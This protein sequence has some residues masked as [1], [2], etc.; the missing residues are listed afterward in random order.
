MLV[1][2]IRSQFCIDGHISLKVF[3][4]E[5]RNNIIIMVVSPCR[6][7]G[8]RKVRPLVGITLFIYVEYSVPLATNESECHSRN[9]NQLIC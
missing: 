8:E 6:P 2:P 5:T 1:L 7:E 4:F 9:G 3:Q